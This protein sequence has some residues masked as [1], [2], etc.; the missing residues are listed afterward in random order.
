MAILARLANER[1]IESQEEIVKE[2]MHQ[3]ANEPIEIDSDL[4]TT[5]RYI[6]YIAGAAIHSIC[7]HLQTRHN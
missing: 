4:C 7:K 3:Q 2:V 6:R 5:I 1:A